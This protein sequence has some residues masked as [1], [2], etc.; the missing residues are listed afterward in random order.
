MQK[1][2]V[3]FTDFYFGGKTFFTMSKR[4]GVLTNEHDIADV[5]VKYD[6][7]K[8]LERIY[9]SVCKND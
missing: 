3:R 7:E 2:L 9:F 6:M 8:N 5:F 4:K 1:C